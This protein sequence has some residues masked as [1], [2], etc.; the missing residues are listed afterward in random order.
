VTLEKIPI[1]D[2]EATPKL[3]ACK[4]SASFSRPRTGEQQ[5]CRDCFL[6]GLGRSDHGGLFDYSPNFHEFAV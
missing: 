2:A 3:M 1:R 5:C 4:G 6:S